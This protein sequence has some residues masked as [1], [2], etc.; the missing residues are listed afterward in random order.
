M[1]WC[2]RVSV[3]GR[4][5]VTAVYRIMPDGHINM[6]WDIDASGALPAALPS[7]LHKSLPRVGL[8]ARLPHSF[9]KVRHET[10]PLGEPNLYM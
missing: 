7:H 6:A 5:G 4:V 2:G 10:P 9:T 8:H 3:D 1:I